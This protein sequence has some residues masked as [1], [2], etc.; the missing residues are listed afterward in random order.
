MIAPHIVGVQ[1]FFLC[2]C[3]KMVAFQI[4]AFER[5]CFPSLKSIKN[6]INEG[7]NKNQTTNVAIQKENINTKF[8]SIVLILRII[9][10]FNVVMKSI[11]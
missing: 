11:L 10:P 3:S 7:I 5:I 2:N 8:E 1:V 6:F 9:S 4:V